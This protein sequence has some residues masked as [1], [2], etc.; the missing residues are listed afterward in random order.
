MTR[1]GIARPNNQ[2]GVGKGVGAAGVA[3]AAGAAIGSHS[4]DKK[5]SGPLSKTD[6]STSSQYSNKSSNVGTTGAS[7]AS[8]VDRSVETDES[9]LGSSKATNAS[10]GSLGAMAGITGG[11]KGSGSNVND[12]SY[13][14]KH[15]HD[16]HHGSGATGAAAGAAAGAAVGSGL[17]HGHNDK[18]SSAHAS[19]QERGTVDSAYS[20]GVKQGAYDTGVKQGAYDSGVKQG[21]YDTGAERGAHDSRSTSGPHGHNKAA[22]G[23]ALGAGLGAGAAS[24]SKGSK[25]EGSSRSN[26]PT[27]PSSKSSGSSYKDTPRPIVE[28]IGISDRDEAAKLAQKT[29]KD[30]VSQGEDIT[31][32]KIVINA[33]TNEVFHVPED[34]LDT[35]SSAFT[36]S[37]KSSS[38]G[39]TGHDHGH[40]HGSTATGAAAG[41][42]GGAAA[43]AG[44]SKHSGRDSHSEYPEK[45]DAGFNEPVK[46]VDPRKYHS[47]HEK[48]KQELEQAAD[49]GQLANIPGQH[50]GT[51]SG[52]TGY[53]TGATG[54]SGQT[55]NYST[56]SGPS[57]SEFS[58]GSGPSGTAGEHT[59]GSNKAGYGAGILGTAAAALG[60][61]KAGHHSEKSEHYGQTG[62]SDQKG[63]SGQTGHPEH[64]DASFNE[65]VKEVDPRKYHKQHEEAKRELEY[66]AEEGELANIPGE[67]TQ[68]QHASGLGSSGTS[69][70]LN[71]NATTG[72]AAGRLAGATGAS[73]LDHHNQRGVSASSQPSDPSGQSGSGL[74]GSGTTHSSSHQDYT[75]VS[76]LGVSDTEQAKQLANAAVAQL[77]GRS[78]VLMSAKELKVDAN[79]GA[80]TDENGK[81]L[82]QLTGLPKHEST[83]AQ[84]G[85]VNPGSSGV[86]GSSAAEHRDVP[87]YGESPSLSLNVG[88]PGGTSKTYGTSSNP[89]VT[90]TSGD[91]SSFLHQD[92]TTRGSG[93]ESGVTSGS[94]ATGGLGSA[95]KST[96]ATQPSATDAHSSGLGSSGKQN[97]QTGLGSGEPR[98]QGGFADT[99]VTGDFSVDPTRSSGDAEE[100]GKMPGSFF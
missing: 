32:G 49:E 87:A 12:T 74:G 23:A 37:N 56:G 97:Y 21:A 68:S 40:P 90:G 13:S 72:A 55:T 67:S 3:G 52:L 42:L 39:T 15:D 24:A 44:L 100:T 30:L 88:A 2:T 35:P 78:D 60:L 17:T 51:G 91:G 62:Y 54:A 85:I 25:Y 65:P 1:R 43:A 92:Q 11:H 59:T 20:A 19:T 94:T 61:S 64:V 86:S 57:G 29:T 14:D 89:G 16:H 98:S 69:V 66:A 75:S 81:F 99:G 4:S 71:T 22:E 28:V 38:H 46:D 47:E 8:G 77:E 79:T 36:S 80:V 10:P 53:S 7:G 50:S 45:I 95:S 31:Q 84:G 83:H 6:T 34:Q 5:S 41:A 33:K 9:R 18:H 82:T 76:V 73:A 70:G 58:A 63:V 48:A 93:L 96:S 27:S 26:V